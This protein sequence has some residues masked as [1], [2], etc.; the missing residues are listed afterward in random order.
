MRLW[1][2]KEESL[3]LFFVFFVLKAGK[4]EEIKEREGIQTDA[5]FTL[6]IVCILT[7]RVVS[8][9]RIKGRSSQRGGGGN[10]I[11]N[12]PGICFS[13]EGCNCEGRYFAMSS[14]VN[15]VTR[16]SSSLDLD[17]M[18]ILQTHTCANQRSPATL[19]LTPVPDK[20]QNAHQVTEMSKQ[21][22]QQFHFI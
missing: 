12:F 9:V 8:L 5:I 18:S 1:G 7:V 21:T 15:E 4:K 19:Q 20:Q 11:M 17:S 2:G 6:S 3:C 13:L 22:H 16:K 14:F 10:P